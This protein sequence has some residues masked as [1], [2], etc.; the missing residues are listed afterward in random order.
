MFSKI[1][2]INSECFTYELYES[3]WWNLF[4]LDFEQS[5][6][7]KML[8]DRINKYAIGYC[9]STRVTTRPNVKCYSVMFEKNNLKFWFHIQKWEIDEINSHN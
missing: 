2:E 3:N 1:K 7:L 9:D 4:D 8:A 5:L 6:D